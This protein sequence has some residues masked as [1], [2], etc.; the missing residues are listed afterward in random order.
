MTIPQIDA[1]IVGAQ[2][3]GTTALS[4]G[5]D[6]HPAVV[7]HKHLEFS[8]FVDPAEWRGS[9]GR[10]H[11][12]AFGS[13]KPE[14]DKLI[15]AKSVGILWLPDAQER[16]AEHNHA[17]RMIAI[18]RNPIDRAYSAF[19]YQK[20]TGREEKGISFQDAIELASERLRRDF[21]RFHHMESSS[22]WRTVWPDWQSAQRVA[23]PRPICGW[24][25]RHDGIWT[26]RRG[27]SKVPHSDSWA[28]SRSRPMSLLPIAVYRRLTFPGAV[29]SSCL[30]GSL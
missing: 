25:R 22:E 26:S 2:K 13:L 5:L 1:I 7:T 15:L 28:M 12:D 30:W 14:D 8:Y 9:Y 6:F 29:S 20:R 11:R 10:A 23:R 17:T 19:L 27:P 3:A 18:L 21:G 4:R 16:Q 24:R